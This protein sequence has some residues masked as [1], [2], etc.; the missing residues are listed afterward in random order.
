LLRRANL[1]HYQSPEL[2]RTNRLTAVAE[3]HEKALSSADPGLGIRRSLGFAKQGRQRTAPCPRKRRAMRQALRPR[4]RGLHPWLYRRARDVDERSSLLACLAGR[5]ERS[6]GQARYLHV[7]WCTTAFSF[8][9][10]RSAR[11]WPIWKKSSMPSCCRRG[12]QRSSSSVTV[13]AASSPGSI[14]CN[15][16]NRYGHTAL[17]RFRLVITLGTPECACQACG[18]GE[19]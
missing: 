12:M 7:M 18:A 9:G 6:Q 13:S 15:V 8:P 5:R 16:K 2:S 19:Q 1:A 3:S 4:R 10:R 11:S 17:G 14:C